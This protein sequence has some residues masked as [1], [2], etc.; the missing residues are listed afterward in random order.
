[1][2]HSTCTTQTESLT[3]KL[4]ACFD[5]ENWAWLVYELKTDGQSLEYVRL[6]PN[7][8]EFFLNDS[9]QKR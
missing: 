5:Q 4:I 7:L 3:T 1:M 2:I 6:I 9:R 8:T